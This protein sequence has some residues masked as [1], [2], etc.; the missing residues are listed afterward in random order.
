MKR[1]QLRRT[2]KQKL[3]RVKNPQIDLIIDQ[4]EW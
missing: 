3:A 1:P 2:K 4:I